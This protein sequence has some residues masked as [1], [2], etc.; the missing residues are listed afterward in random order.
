MALGARMIA[1]RLGWNDDIRSMPDCGPRVISI[2]RPEPRI[3]MTFEYIVMLSSSI[4]L[5]QIGK[6]HQFQ[7]TGSKVKRGY[8]LNI[9]WAK[10]QLD[11]LAV[12]RLGAEK[13]A[14]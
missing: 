6:L 11:F 8:Y 9:I 3:C 7:N 12:K 2:V 14:R 1:E 10:H 4:C 5:S 13:M